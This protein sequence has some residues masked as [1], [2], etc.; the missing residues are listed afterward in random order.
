MALRGANRIRSPAYNDAAATFYPDIQAVSHRMSGFLLLALWCSHI[1]YFSISHRQAEL[2]TSIANSASMTNGVA[3]AAAES[4]VVITKI[5]YPPQAFYL[6]ELD[7]NEL[8]S[9]DYCHG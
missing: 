7:R 5:L 4:P 6:F 8:S 2:I 9:L 1:E 3:N